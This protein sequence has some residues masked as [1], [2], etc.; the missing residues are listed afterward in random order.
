MAF[1]RIGAGELTAVNGL[2][3]AIGPDASVV[4]LDSLTADRFAQVIRGICGT[5]AAALTKATPATV[6]AV[7]SGIEGA[8][9]HPVLLAQQQSELTA[10]GAT[11][12]EVVNLLTTQEAHNLTSPPTRTWFIHYTVWMSEPAATAPGGAAA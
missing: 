11:P 10:Y 9:R 1:K 3:A 2:C 4:I 12:R 8:G 7:V 6:R 5:P